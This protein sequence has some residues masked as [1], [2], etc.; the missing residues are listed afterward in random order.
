MTV[1]QQCTQVQNGTSSDLFN[2]SNPLGV[3]VYNS[4]LKYYEIVPLAP[5]TNF[6]STAIATPEQDSYLTLNPANTSTNV[7]GETVIE[8]DCLRGLVITSTIAQT[9]AQTLLITGYDEKEVQVQASV[10]MAV[11]ATSIYTLKGFK[12]VLS[13]QNTSTGSLGTF[14][15]GTGNGISL[16]SHLCLGV[17]QIIDCKYIGAEV[18][19]VQ[20]AQPGSS[21]QV[22]FYFNNWRTTEPT[23]LTNDARGMFFV[24]AAPNGSNIF[25]VLYHVYG[26]N[27][28]LQAQLANNDYTAYTLIG[29]PSPGPYPT[30][31]QAS[32]RAANTQPPLLVAGDETGLQYPGQMDEYNVYFNNL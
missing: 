10:T 7:K 29:Y 6:V 9:T 4:P 25:T 28:E 30:P 1:R 14:N 8:L 2:V 26:A 3:G 19:P 17:Q 31:P 13:V 11:S 5:V 24:Y 18:T 20:S 23:A 12:S 21:S 15:V 32:P 16:P 27:S 22:G